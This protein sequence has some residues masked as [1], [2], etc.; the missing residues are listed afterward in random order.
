MRGK[1]SAEAFTTCVD[2]DLRGRF[3]LDGRVHLRGKDA[4]L[5][6]LCHKYQI[7]QRAVFL[8]ALA[9]C[10]TRVLGDV[11]VLLL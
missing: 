4:D 5:V 11:V 6:L 10:F 8:V 7:V 9:G 1:A 3:W 2:V